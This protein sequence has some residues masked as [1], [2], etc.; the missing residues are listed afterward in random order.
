[1][2]LDIDPMDTLCPFVLYSCCGPTHTHTHTHT[3]TQSQKGHY[4]SLNPTKCPVTFTNSTQIH[5]YECFCLCVCDFTGIVIII[6][7]VCVYVCV[8]VSYDGFAP[9]AAPVLQPPHAATVLVTHH[10]PGADRQ[11]ALQPLVGHEHLGPHT[12]TQ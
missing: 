3:H 7:C 6:V 11:V 9:E 12:H 8:C 5:S 4:I 10:T 2:T 1:L